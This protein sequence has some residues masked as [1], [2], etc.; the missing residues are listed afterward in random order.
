M[1]EQASSLAEFVRAAGK[2]KT[3]QSLVLEYRALQAGYAV[4][5]RSGNTLQIEV[6]GAWQAFQDLNGPSS[7]AAA[8]TVCL[9]KM[10]TRRLLAAAGVP[11]PASNLFTLDDRD[12]GWAYAG[13]L[14]GPVAVR[15]ATEPMDRGLT[16]GLTEEDAFAAAWRSAA[17]FYEPPQVNPLLADDVLRPPRII[18][19]EQADPVTVSVFVAGGKMIAAT[20]WRPASVQGDGQRSVRALIAAKNEE[21]AANPLLADDPVPLDPELLPG[22]HAAGIDLADIPA[23]GDTVVL[24][25][26]LEPAAGADSVDV[27]DEVPAG[28]AAV[29][30]AAVAAIPGL[31]YGAVDLALPAGA[32]PSLEL[33][34]PPQAAAAAPTTPTEAAA[35]GATTP[36]PG[37]TAEPSVPPADPSR[38]APAATVRA[39]VFSPLMTAQFPA[40]G[41]PRDLAGAVLAC[42]APPTG[43]SRPE[44]SA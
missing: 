39:V 1:A 23:N 25:D 15:P 6:G 43:A 16:A 8:K 20:G 40:V 38:V 10:L 4:K 11:V 12:A 9:N 32:L 18:V 3:K 5:R 22:C 44:G 30:V 7:S 37:A 26:S 2:G 13:T 24:G 35:A 29:A 28:V 21:R 19:E 17:A 34:G 27:T 14:S 33:P 42:Y 36:P 31:S 41:T